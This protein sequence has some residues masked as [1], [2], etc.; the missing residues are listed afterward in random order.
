MTH[1]DIQTATASPARPERGL[2]AV[3][4]NEP[5]PEAMRSALQAADSVADVVELRID[6]L[7]HPEAARLPD[8]LADRPCP[9]IV[10]CRAVREGGRWPGSEARRLDILRE[11][12][13]LGAEYVDVEA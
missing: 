4:L 2:I 7:D 11:A 3:A 12:I 9:V 6:L 8:L 5:T 13:A 10:T 1:P